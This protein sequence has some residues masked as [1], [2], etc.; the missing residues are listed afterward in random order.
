M[1][2]K[3]ILLCSYIFNGIGLTVFAYSRQFWLQCLSRLCSGFCQTFHTIYTPIFVDTY[4]LNSTKSMYLS[5]MLLSAPL[6][7]LQ[8]F[9]MA[10]YINYY[11]HWRYTFFFIGLMSFGCAIFICAIPGRYVNIDT[12]I[13]AKVKQSSGD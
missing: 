13:N 10:A 8:G 1:P 4:A 12:V 3:S 11:M 7:A 5:L 2:Y 9:I 6:G